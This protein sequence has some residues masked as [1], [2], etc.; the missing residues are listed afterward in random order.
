MR[1]GLIGLAI[2]GTLAVGTAGAALAQTC[3][4]GQILQAGLCQP[5]AA[6]APSATAVP[7]TAAPAPTA[8]AVPPAAA[9]ART[10]A[11]TTTT[12]VQTGTSGTSAAPVAAPT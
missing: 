6:P 9:P 8:T 5:V 7:P 11:S 2:V 10:T 3:P 12:T 4:P 1:N